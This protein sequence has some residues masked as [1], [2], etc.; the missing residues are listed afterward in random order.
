MALGLGSITSVV[1]AIVLAGV[2]LGIGL[3][4]LGSVMDQLTGEAADATNKTIVAL[5]GFADW[6]TIII[7]VAAA[8][9]VLGLLFGV[10]GGMKR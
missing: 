4:I 8:A 7:V 2:V 1:I 5:G 3:Y 6:F 9:I 10:F